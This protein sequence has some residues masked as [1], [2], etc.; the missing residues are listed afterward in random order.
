MEVALYKRGS[1][2]RGIGGAF[3]LP[4]VIRAHVLTSNPSVKSL[5]ESHELFGERWRTTKM[6]RLV[7]AFHVLGKRLELRAA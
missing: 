7:E 1:S 3:F 4:E 2:V 5:F 6:D